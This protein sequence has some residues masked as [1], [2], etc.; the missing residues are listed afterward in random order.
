MDDV[1]AAI[2]YGGLT[3]NKVISRLKE[4]YRKNVK[5]DELPEYMEETVEQKRKTAAKCL[6]ENG[7]IVKGINNCL[8]RIS[9]CCNPVP[10]M[11]L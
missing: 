1:Y 4:E 9:R 6:P 11:I 5:P 7:V 2:G 8:I 10:V 3:A